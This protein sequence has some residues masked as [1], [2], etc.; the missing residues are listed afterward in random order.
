MQLTAISVALLDNVLKGC[1]I[2]FKRNSECGLSD[3]QININ[4][5]T[6]DSIHCADVSGIDGHG[7]EL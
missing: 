2:A 3:E 5:E 4:D 1:R 6:M 7:N